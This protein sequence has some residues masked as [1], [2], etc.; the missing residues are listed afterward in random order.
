METAV[1]LE[2]AALMHQTRADGKKVVVVAGPVVVHTGGVKPLAA[3]IRGGW[4]QA[5]LAGNALGVHDIR[6]RAAGH[7][8]RRATKD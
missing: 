1:R 2:T 3:M 8:A 5:L 7:I 4:V 6:V